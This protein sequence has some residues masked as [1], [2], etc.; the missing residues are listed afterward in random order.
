MFLNPRA[1]SL[2]S[3]IAPPL[4]PPPLNQQERDRAAHIHTEQHTRWVDS[5][6]AADLGSFV[7]LHAVEPPKQSLKQTPTAADAPAPLPASARSPLRSLDNHATTTPKITPN[8]TPATASLRPS[9]PSRL[10][11]ALVMA[12]AAAPT[13]PF[14][15]RREEFAEN[16][17]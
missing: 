10:T 9:S 15:P 2:A 6:S 14:V 1:Q 5:A 13:S 7:P 4:L 3:S 12:A 17:K 11:R 16:Q 8:L